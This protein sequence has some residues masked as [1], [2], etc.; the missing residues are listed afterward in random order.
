MRVL[1]LETRLSFWEDKGVRM[2]FVCICMQ[3]CG[4]FS[5]LCLRSELGKRKRD[6]RVAT[7]SLCYRTSVGEVQ[8]SEEERY[9]ENICLM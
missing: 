3:F 2:W 9:K 5:C 7:F 6:Q 1:L 8:K 4:R